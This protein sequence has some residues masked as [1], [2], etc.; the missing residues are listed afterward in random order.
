MKRIF[1]FIICFLFVFLF[2]FINNNNKVF[3]DGNK[4]NYQEKVLFHSDTMI[5]LYDNAN[6]VSI[7]KKEEFIEVLLGE[8]VTFQV[9][10]DYLDSLILSDS[11]VF[12]LTTYEEKYFISLINPT[13]HSSKN[14]ELSYIG[15]KLALF[16]NG[17]IVCGEKQNDACIYRYDRALNLYSYYVY[18]CDGYQSFTELIVINDNI[19]A[20]GIKDATHGD[21]FSKVGSYGE[22]KTFLCVIDQYGKIVNSYYFNLLQETERPVYF[23]KVPNGIIIGV[24][25]F[26][27]IYYYL[28]DFDKIVS[29]YSA[30][31][32]EQ[33]TQ[34]ISDNLSYFEV[35]IKDS[36]LILESNNLSYYLYPTY[37]YLNALL[38]N[39]YLKVILQIGRT[40]KELTY[41]EYHIDYNKTIYINK[42]NSDFNVS[43]EIN[44]SSFISVS[45][46][47]ADATVNIIKTD[48]FF[49]KQISGSYQITYDI[50]FTNGENLNLDSDII[51][52]TFTNVLD[53]GIYNDELLLSFTGY[54]KLDGNDVLNGHIVKSEG[55]HK[56]ELKNN[57][58]IIDIYM[59]NIVKDYQ[60][61]KFVNVDSDYTVNKGEY[62][63]IDLTNS[64][65][66]YVEEDIRIWIDDIE[67]SVVKDDN[68]RILILDCFDSYGVKE[69]NV[70][71][72]QINQDKYQLN[73]TVKVNVLKNA[74]MIEVIE[75]TDSILN[76]KIDVEDY[77]KTIVN[78]TFKIFDGLKLVKEYSIYEG[79]QQISLENINPLKSYTIKGYLNYQ[80]G[81]NIIKSYEYFNYCGTI[82]K[83]SIKL[84]DVKVSYN[85][86][87][88]DF[89]NTKMYTDTT[90]LKHVSMMIADVDLSSKYQKMFN[91]KRVIVAG[92]ITLVIILGGIMIGL[93]KQRKK[94]IMN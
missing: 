58:G 88:V 51:I 31:Y 71:S 82:N 48:P 9:K 92:S 54:G 77:D 4:L 65:E 17:I 50:N 52:E 39:G 78:V 59:F 84:L 12:L 94:K 6:R 83:K 66:E 61:A 67:Y 42:D 16:Q 56:L 38:E 18:E 10:G 30:E 75:E 5:E 93:I 70:Q 33:M 81:D 13:K 57:L 86:G 72:L 8:E 26:S 24:S 79:E 74:P 49:N 80:L 21:L 62:L 44:H 29:F 35:G 55:V 27:S 43:D 32:K 91:Y 11:E 60:G 37:S 46:L 7:I 3:A 47:F 90:K 23:G 36:N 22:I 89:V 20:L 69:L 25:D 64:L 1:K 41:F 53:G 40:I 76:L 14:I 85:N 19:Y 73:Q 45:S 68:R 28:Y 63:Q 34:I 87:M 2:I 15:N